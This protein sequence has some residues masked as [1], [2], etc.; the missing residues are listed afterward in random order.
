MIQ[1]NILLPLSG[2]TPESFSVMDL[3]GCRWVS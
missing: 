2:K 1:A 3:M